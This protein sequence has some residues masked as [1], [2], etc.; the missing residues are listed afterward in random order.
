MQQALQ[1]KPYTKNESDKVKIIQLTD[2]TLHTSNKRHTTS[3]AKKVEKSFAKNTP[4]RLYGSLATQKNT[5]G[6]SSR[7][8]IRSNI[9]KYI[10][11]DPN[12]LEYIKR[13]EAKGYKVV[14]ELPENG[15]PIYLGKD[16]HEFMESKKG[17]RIL[18]RLDKEKN[19]DT[20]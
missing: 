3:P 5:N 19:R 7:M 14:I 16:A 11:Q 20:M 9:I 2:L 8:E 1:F 13:E 12:M 4:E 15:L 10:M 6:K 18:R 17:K